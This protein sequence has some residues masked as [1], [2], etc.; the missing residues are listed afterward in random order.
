MGF[1]GASCRARSKREMRRRPR[2]GA[3][4]F[5]AGL[6]GRLEENRATVGSARTR[7]TKQHLFFR[8]GSR[9]VRVDGISVAPADRPVLHAPIPVGPPSRRP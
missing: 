3:P 4:R 8:A 1:C 6:K 9:M 7:E 2:E 5:F